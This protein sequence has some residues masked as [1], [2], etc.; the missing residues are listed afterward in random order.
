MVDGFPGTASSRL[1]ISV[2]WFE[3]SRNS[4]GVGPTMILFAAVLIVVRVRRH[5]AIPFV[6]IS[7]IQVP[8]PQ[9]CPERQR[10]VV[11]GDFAL[12][13]K[14]IPSE[15]GKTD[16][17]S[18]KDIICGRAAEHLAEGRTDALLLTADGAGH[19][20]DELPDYGVEQNPVE[21]LYVVCNAS[22]DRCA[23]LGNMP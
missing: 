2:P 10:D 19:A 11:P 6:R 21:G 23:A 13:Q 15:C 18:V 4:F 3:H 17:S 16:S 8:P 7:E 9:Q 5:G 12:P 1:F 14:P 22:L 20:G